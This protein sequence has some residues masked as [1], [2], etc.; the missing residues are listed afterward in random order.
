M[1]KENK[2]LLF[3][4]IIALIMVILFLISSYLTKTYIIQLQAFIKQYYLL[5]IIVY[6]VLGVLDASGVPISNVPLIPVVVAG[7]GLGMG[8]I[9]TS[10]GWF[11]GSIIAFAIARGYGTEFINR[12]VPLEK[13]ES[14]QKYI[15]EKDFFFS[16]IFFRILMPHDFVNYGYGI[17]TKIKRKPFLAYSGLGIVISVFI[18][19]II[20]NFSLPYQILVI[21]G[22]VAIFYFVFYT[23]PRIKR[24][25]MKRK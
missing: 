11:G 25:R 2:N 12:F 6:L 24:R 16:I 21:L 13:M 10:A 22:A 15:P 3:A 14:F 5:G 7:Y 4:A 18:Y 9:L 1:K 17:F 8:I 19:S 23:Y 20:D